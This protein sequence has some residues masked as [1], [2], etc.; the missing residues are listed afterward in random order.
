[1]HWSKTY[2]LKEQNELSSKR[3]VSN[4]KYLY[5]QDT[6]LPLTQYANKAQLSSVSYVQKEW[7]HLTEQNENTALQK[8]SNNVLQELQTITCLA[9]NKVKGQD[10]LSYFLECKNV[11]R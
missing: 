8:H 5:P 2:L 9:I 4:P 7:V 6:P 11:L 3:C 1:M 10:Y